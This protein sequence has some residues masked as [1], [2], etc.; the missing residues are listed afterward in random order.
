MTKAPRTGRTDGIVDK[1]L[2][3]GVISYLPERVRNNPICLE[4]LKQFD[5][6]RA[7]LTIS[8]YFWEPVEQGEMGNWL[9]ISLGRL[10][11]LMENLY[12]AKGGDIDS[13]PASRERWRRSLANT[14]YSPAAIA[15]DAAGEA[16]HS[17]IEPKGPPS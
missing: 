7:A 15:E 5:P 14:R 16:L 13:L 9:N 11:A 10:L 2:F 1:A 3:D 8:D 17:Q 6:E 12:R 4:R